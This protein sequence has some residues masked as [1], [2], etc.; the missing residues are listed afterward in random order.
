[1]QYSYRFLFIDVLIKNECKIFNALYICFH[2]PKKFQIAF[3]KFLKC[4]TLAII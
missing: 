4:I 2:V 1:M 3:F